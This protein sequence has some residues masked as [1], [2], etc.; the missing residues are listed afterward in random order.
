MRVYK[1]ITLLTGAITCASLIVSILLNFLCVSCDFWINVSLAIFGSALLASLT[2]LV[3]YFYEKRKTLESFMCNTLR[4]VRF[5]NKYDIH[6]STDEKVHFFIDYCELDR[7]AWDANFGEMA[8]FFEKL[9]GSQKYIYNSIYF[10]IRD[11]TNSVAKHLWH[12]RWYLN[13]TGRNEIAI[14]SFIEEIES[15]LI[16][17][18]ETQIPTEYDENG[19]PTLFTQITDFSS[20]L[21][22][23]IY[24]ELYGRYFT[25]MYGKKQ[26]RNLMEEK[27]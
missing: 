17:T 11:F 24:K 15:K 25:I 3:T 8:F 22:K 14:R 23:N 12:F 6:F 7:D 18:K 20:L 26:S 10:P 27:E 9:T 4:I 2:A 13:G 16:E 5:I 19:H 1:N 21:V